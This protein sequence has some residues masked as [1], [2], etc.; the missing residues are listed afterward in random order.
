MEVDELAHADRRSKQ[1]TRIA[2]FPR[3]AFPSSINA[4]ARMIAN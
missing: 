3:P 2:H 4:L 1:V